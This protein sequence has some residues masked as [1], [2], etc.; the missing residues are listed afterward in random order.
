MSFFRSRCFRILAVAAA[1]LSLP[2]ALT[3]QSVAQIDIPKL[4]NP[5]STSISREQQQQLG[6]QAAG[7]VY[8]QM[9]VL[10]DSSSETQYVRQ[11]GKR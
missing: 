1:A 5:G 2:L 6:F 3:D 9:P 8:K 7:E 4:P 11:L 10:P